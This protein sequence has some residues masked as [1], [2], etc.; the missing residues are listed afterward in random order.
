MI[1]IVTGDVTVGIVLVVQQAQEWLL[2]V[3]LLR[4]VAVLQ[5]GGWE[6]DIPNWLMDRSAGGSA[7]AGIH[8]AVGGLGSSEWETAAP[9]MFI[10]YAAHPLA[11]SVTAAL[12]KSTRSETFS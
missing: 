9:I 6:A 10:T 5:P 7:F 4:V 11:T 12:T 3:R 8:S 1:G 2:H